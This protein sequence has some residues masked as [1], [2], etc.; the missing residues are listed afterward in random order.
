M[1]TP[2]FNALAGKAKDCGSAAVF[3]SLLMLAGAWISIAGPTLLAALK[4]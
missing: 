2:D 3:L 4:N 1:A